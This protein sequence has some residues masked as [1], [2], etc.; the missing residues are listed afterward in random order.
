[1]SDLRIAI[2]GVGPWGRNLLR[3]FSSVRGA[4][5]TAVCDEHPE[6]LAAA[7]APRAL[8]TSRFE[9]IL[10]DSS[11]DAVVLATPPELHAEQTLQA[12]AA[13]KHVFVEKP[14]ATNTRD[15]L[16]VE[17]FARRAGRQ[18]MVGHI[19]R[20]HP[21]LVRL[22]EIV[23]RGEIGPLRSLEATRLGAGDVA[24]EKTAWWALA[25]HDVS[26]MCAVVGGA[27]AAVSATLRRSPVSGAPEVCATLSF[28]NGC[29]GAIVTAA[30]AP[31]KTRRLVVAGTTGVAVFDDVDPIS[32]L[33]V[34]AH[35]GRGFDPVSTDGTEPLL[36][37]ARC[38]VESIAT[39]S[40]TV[41]DATEGRA[42]VQVL[43]AAERSWKANSML[44]TL[45]AEERYGAADAAE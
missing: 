5:V 14:L 15:A 1:L 9:D 25:P 32:K 23:R 29:A 36:L 19:L 35:A 44:V 4:R 42:V 17:A 18:V 34:Q 13:R 11:L 38:F 37:E 10:D 20:H 39:G 8:R 30:R 7:D 24:D 41:T 6:R 43:E 26:A 45:G 22:M 27:P 12:L 31:Q 2:V 3:V 21:A 33:R 28:A 16:E 40:S